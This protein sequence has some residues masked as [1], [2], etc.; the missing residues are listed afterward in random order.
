[1]W[2]VSDEKTDDLKT[3]QKKTIRIEKYNYRF[4]ALAEANAVA[5][6]QRRLATRWKRP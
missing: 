4:P 2:E 6:L 1:M 5:K 3:L